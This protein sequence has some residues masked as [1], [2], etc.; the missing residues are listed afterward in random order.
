MSI[1]G[2]LTLNNKPHRRITLERRDTNKASPAI[3]LA[4]VLQRVSRP[5]S[6]EGKPDNV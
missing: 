4:Y 6:S 2:F 3:S 1:N 5:E